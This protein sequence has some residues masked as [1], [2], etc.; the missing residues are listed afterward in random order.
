MDESSSSAAEADADKEIRSPRKSKIQQVGVHPLFLFLP[1]RIP[2]LLPGDSAG[3][4]VT[5]MPDFFT[6]TSRFVTPY[7]APNRDYPAGEIPP[8]VLSPLGEAWTQK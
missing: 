6:S 2:S 5:G 3:I 1:K 8:P 4:P 7:L